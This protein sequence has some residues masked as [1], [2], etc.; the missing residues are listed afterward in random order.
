MVTSRIHNNSQ[1]HTFE[2]A[3]TK[4]NDA[5]FSLYIIFFYLC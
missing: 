1:G 5:I 3:K 4:K 2:Y